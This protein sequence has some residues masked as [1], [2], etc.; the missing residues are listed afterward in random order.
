LEI[1]EKAESTLREELAE[2]R[3]RR[4]EAERQREDMRRELE[5]LREARESPETAEEQQG[6]GQPNPQQE[7]L[8]R[9]HRDLG[10]GGG[11]V[12]DS[13]LSCK[14][15]FGSACKGLPTD[16]KRAGKLYCVLHSPRV[17][18]DLA[19]FEGAIEKKRK[20]ED[21]DFRGVYFPGNQ[22]LASFL[23]DGPDT[24]FEGPVD[25]IQA[26]FVGDADF[27]EAIFKRRADFSKATFKGEAIFSTSPIPP[28]P[29]ET[30]FQGMADFSKA[31]FERSADFYWAFF[32]EADFSKATFERD[33]NFTGA[34]FVGGQTSPAP[35]SKR[36][37]DFGVYGRT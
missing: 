18:K 35:Y 20:D 8:R 27:S 7:K 33:A 14:E 4:E 26:T 25:F 19:A 34:T 12:A 3:R 30:D 23:R 2:E 29:I 24:T 31:T 28:G 10:G 16:D 13:V 36:R 21:F 1:S 22:R 6:R 37:E 11:S 5:A 9:A 15:E 17:N 32:T